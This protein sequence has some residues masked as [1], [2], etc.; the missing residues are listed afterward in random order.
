[1][2]KYKVPVYIEAVASK[3]IGHVECGSVEEFKREAERLWESQEWD[4]PSANCTNDFDLGDF[5]LDLKISQKD[6]E[7]CGND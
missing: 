5:D 1:M 7:F 6:L 3:C 4:H 2:S